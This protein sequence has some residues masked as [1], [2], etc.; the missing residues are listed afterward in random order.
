LASVYDEK[1]KL[2]L[3]YKGARGQRRDEASL[4][5]RPERLAG[6]PTSSIASGGM[7]AVSLATMPGPCSTA[8]SSAGCFSATD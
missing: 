5:P 1:G 6:E 3:H 4:A 8:V 7:A 2:Y